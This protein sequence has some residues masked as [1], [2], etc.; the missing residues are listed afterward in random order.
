[1]STELERSLASREWSGLEVAIAGSLASLSREEALERLGSNGARLVPFPTERTALLVVGQAGIPLGDDGGLARPLREARAFQER[2]S[3]IEIITEEEFLARLGLEEAGAQLR[4]LYTTAQLARILDIPG[5]RIQAWVRHGLIRPV[6]TTRRL[7]FF[8]FRQVARAKA[9]CRLSADGVRPAEIRRSLE[10]LARWWPEASASLAQLEALER[11]GPLTVRTPEGALAET[12]GQLRLEFPESQAS[13]DETLVLG[14]EVWFQRGLRLEEED[15][16]EEAARAYSRALDPRAPR[17]EVAFNLGNVLYGLGRA[18]EAA[19][20]FALA[21]E[22]DPEYV[23]AWNNLGNAL[24]GLGRQE[25]AARA[26]ARAL[27]I[28]PQYADAHFNLAETL[29]A[30]G[31]VQRA[32]AH[33]KAYLALD[34]ISVWAEEARARLRRTE[35]P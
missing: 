5:Q 3:P 4:T 33:W 34:P 29:A 13:G 23:E 26:L 12:S 14:V 20:A 8:D 11:H 17:A 25:E 24:S 15:R 9:L 32:R 31:E 19:A 1:M 27:A 28:E 18:A 10:E 7:A 21:T 6:R 35:A 22:V 2:G 16:P 30:G